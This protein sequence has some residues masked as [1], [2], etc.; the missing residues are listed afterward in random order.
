MQAAHICY[1]KTT[2]IQHGRMNTPSTDTL[3][4]WITYHAQTR[5]SALALVDC[6]QGVERQ[7]SWEALK[8]AVIAAHAQLERW[9]VKLGDRVGA[10]AS[11]R[12]ELII[13]QAACA[14]AGFIYAPLNV[15]LSPAELE[16]ILAQLEPRVLL[17]DQTRADALQDERWRV[18]QIE[19]LL[20]HDEQAPP[21]PL[22]DDPHRLA[23]LLYTSGSTGMSKGATF[24]HGALAASVRQFVEVLALDHAAINLAIAP[25]YHVAG[26]GVLTLPTLFAGG[27]NIIT[28]TDQTTELWPIVHTYGV[29]HTFG[30]PT[31]WQRWGTQQAPDHHTLRLGVIGGAPSE[32]ALHRQWWQRGVELCVGYGMTE[33]AP[34]VTLARRGLLERLPLSVGEPGPLVRLEVRDDAGQ[35]LGANQ[36]GELHVFAPN[37][38]RGYW[39][40]PHR[41]RGLHDG[42]FATSD[43]ATI[44]AQGAVTLMG[45]KDEMIITG[46]LKVYPQEVERAMR[47]LDEVE[48]VGVFGL[49]DDPEY[50]QRVI[51]C[52]V[53]HDD[54]VRP[55]LAQTRLALESTLARYKH[56]KVLVALKALPRLGSGKLDR[57]ALKRAALPLITTQDQ[58]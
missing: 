33:A 18:M 49:D 37:L 14:R 54:L 28:S 8:R 57:R 44:D 25:L 45:R 12:A 1:R 20:E 34:M 58:R 42:A 29:T 17:V 11:N 7:W 16:L 6:G 21:A 43:M 27:T 47:S 41:A 26:L 3:W 38:M 15:R 24:D 30:V 55:T 39:P 31:L 53:W 2:I 56:P 32:H 9:G 19:R 36:T 50:G 35:A 22:P 51:A 4:G 5:P 52:V 48:D 13:A 23:M 10:L 46:G 40:E